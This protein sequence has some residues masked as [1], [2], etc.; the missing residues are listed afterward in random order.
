MMIYP[1]VIAVEQDLLQRLRDDRRLADWGAE[2][3]PLPGFTKDGW[4]R[5]FARYPAVGTYCAR[6][7]YRE[8]AGQA[9]LE[10]APLAILCAGANYRAPAAALSGDS[11]QPGATHLVER[12]RQVVET[13]PLD[14]SNL[15]ALRPLRWSLAWC[16]SQ[17]AVCVL[18][19]EATL[20]RPAR[21]TPGEIDAY[22]SSYD[23]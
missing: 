1:D 8:Q 5:L 9:R 4:A 14:G 16:S 23:K 22:G 7:E 11:E 2:V 18:E 3:A 6:A 21:P 19:V 17:I 13:W 20:A 15:R 12:C 10:V